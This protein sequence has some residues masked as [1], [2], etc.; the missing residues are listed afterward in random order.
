MVG[1][2]MKRGYTK[3][4]YTKRQNTKRRY[5]KRRYTKRRTKRRIIK[6]MKNYRK[7]TKKKSKLRAAP[8]QMT[9]IVSSAAP[10]QMVRWGEPL[11]GDSNNVDGFEIPTNLINN[12]DGKPWYFR[13]PKPDKGRRGYLDETKYNTSVVIKEKIE[14]LINSQ[15]IPMLKEIKKGFK[16]GTKIFRRTPMNLPYELSVIT[17]DKLQINL[18]DDREYDF[19]Y[20]FGYRGN[21][22]TLVCIFCSMIRIMVDFIKSDKEY[23][24]W[25]QR[26]GDIVNKEK[27]LQLVEECK[28]FDIAW[29]WTKKNGAFP[30]F[31][32]FGRVHNL[33]ISGSK[34][35]GSSGLQYITGR[36]WNDKDGTIYGNVS[37]M[38]NKKMAN[39]CIDMLLNPGDGYGA[40]D[41]DPFKEDVTLQQWAEYKP[42]AKVGVIYE[43]E[44]HP[45]RY[46][47]AKSSYKTGGS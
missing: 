30:K 28:Q 24:V 31:L 39:H 11:N 34:D 26:K 1:R 29:L 17:K 32:Q 2:S 10:V 46:M 37:V 33:D 20:L 4:R 12:E 35:L 21:P 40:L 5:T 38:M 7:N 15:L 47:D 8:V 23:L 41:T 9:R 42:G 44:G 43:Q 27:F 45:I 6:N 36:Q 14:S 19:Q 25:I 13:L 22:V 18:P 16:N 3:R